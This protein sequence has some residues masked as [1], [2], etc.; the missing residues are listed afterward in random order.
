MNLTTHFTLEELTAS[1]VATRR[2]LD[3]T[4]GPDALANLK[5][6]AATLEL[7]RYEFGAPVL[8]SSGYRSPA[9]NQA[10]GGAANSAHLNGLAVDFMI[11]A[12]GRPLDVALKISASHLVFDQ[13]IHEFGAW[14]HLGV[15]KKGAAPR[16][17]LL[18]IDRLGARPGLL[19]VRDG[20]S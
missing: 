2:G 11:P 10:V 14:V 16:M 3:N 19:E 13:L 9:V 20:N 17:Q 1:Q 8:V 6:L 5:F 15:V 18:T 4:P 12:W 7:V